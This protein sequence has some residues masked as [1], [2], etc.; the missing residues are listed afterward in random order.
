MN[1]YKAHMSPN[2]T[3]SSAIQRFEG[4][5]AIKICDGI[6]FDFYMG[7]PELR[8]CTHGYYRYVG[9]GSSKHSSMIN[10]QGLL[11]LSSPD[12]ICKI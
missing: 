2:L 3:G 8:I 9:V 7:L 11:F 10:L 1:I 5:D 12:G 4:S 6:T